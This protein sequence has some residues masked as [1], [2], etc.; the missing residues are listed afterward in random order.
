[1][2]TIKRQRDKEAEQ[3]E[4]IYIEAKTGRWR[5]EQANKRVSDGWM[6]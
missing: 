1:M 5:E 2:K 3:D 6:L 4:G